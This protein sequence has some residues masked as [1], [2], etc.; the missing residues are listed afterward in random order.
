MR[1]IVNVVGKSGQASTKRHISNDGVVRFDDG[2]PFRLLFENE[3]KTAGRILYCYDA[4]DVHEI[5]SIEQGEIVA[6]EQT[7][8]YQRT[9]RG[10]GALIEVVFQ[11]AD[12]DDDVRKIVAIN[13]DYNKDG[14]VV[15]YGDT[16]ADETVTGRTVR[17]DDDPDLHMRSSRI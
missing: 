7:F 12:S 13:N 2:E 17:R 16:S 15:K 10:Q 11:R 3:W 4:G 1:F 9:P 14:S 8:I 5:A 6:S